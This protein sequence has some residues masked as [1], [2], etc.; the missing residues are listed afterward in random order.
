MWS[1]FGELLRQGRRRAG[2]T[3][4]ELAERAG[5]SARTIRSLES[6]RHRDPRL[7]TARELAAALCRTADERDELMSVLATGGLSGARS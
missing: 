5:V 4:E 7:S 3:Q 2:L 1:T 6:G